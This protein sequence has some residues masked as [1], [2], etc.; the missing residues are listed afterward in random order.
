MPEA[1]GTFAP[2][3]I[4]RKPRATTHPGIPDQARAAR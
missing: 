1:T 4:T 3:A 2:F